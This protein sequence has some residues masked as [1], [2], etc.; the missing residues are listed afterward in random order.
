MALGSAAELI[1]FTR[2]LE[3]RR[4][5]HRVA[6]ANGAVVTLESVD[7]GIRPEVAETA[8]A[9]APRSHDSATV[10]ATTLPGGIGIVGASGREGFG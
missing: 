7:L 4:Q 1:P 10:D 8:N 6:V 5:L 3:R 2:F 9:G